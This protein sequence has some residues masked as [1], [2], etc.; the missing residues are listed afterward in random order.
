MRLKSGLWASA[1]VRRAET[2]GAMAFI[3]AKGDGDAG[4][5]LIKVNTLDGQAYMLSSS[6]D[7]DGS[8]V[9]F[10]SASAEERDLDTK[11]NKRRDMDPDLWVIEIEDR[12]GRHF[13][14]ETVR[15]PE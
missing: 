5:C 13:L 6:T 1:L 12:A 7:M 9:W 14:T 11:I 3:V 2:A 8:R 10:R 15:D 4:T